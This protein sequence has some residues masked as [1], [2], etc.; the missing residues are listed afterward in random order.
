MAEAK[1]KKRKSKIRLK[2]SA[3]WTIASLFM[4]TAIIIALI[5]VQNGGVSAIAEY[6]VPSTIGEVLDGEN[7]TLKHGIVDGTSV[8]GVGTVEYAFPKDGDSQN[9]TD[10]TNGTTYTYTKIDMSTMDNK[11]VPVP[12]FSLAKNS[13]SATS[14]NCLSKYLGIAGSGSTPAGGTVNLG[15]DV[16]VGKDLPSA[17]TLEYDDKAT[18]TDQN[19]DGVVVTTYKETKHTTTMPNDS[20]ISYSY[21]DRVSKTKTYRWIVDDAELN[22][23]HLEFTESEWSTPEYFVK[24]NGSEDKNQRT[25]YYI[26]DGAFK[27]VGN[28]QTMTIPQNISKIGDSSFE[29]CS[30]LASV[31]IGI[32]CESI[33]DK[34]FAGCGNLNN[35]SFDTISNLKTIG[36]GAFA[37]IGA[38]SITLPSS[39]LSV[40]GSG[41]FFRCPNLS[42]F[43]MSNTN[44]TTGLK[45]GCYVFS[46]CPIS[47]ITLTNVTSIASHNSSGTLISNPATGSYSKD[48]AQCG[49]FTKQNDQSDTLRSVQFPAYSG[50]IPYGTF[51]GDNN[52]AYVRFFNDG[53]AYDWKDESEQQQ[54]ADE[55]YNEPDNFYIMGDTPTMSGPQAY[56]YAAANGITYGYM[57]GDV[58]TYELTKNGYKYTF[59]VLDDNNCV[60]T[61]IEPSEIVTPEDTMV[62][63]SK[64]AQ[65]NVKEIS[66]EAVKVS[67]IA[68]PSSLEIPDTIETIGDKAFTNM[69]NL[70]TVN[71]YDA[72]GSSSSP[73]ITLGNELFAGDK[74]LTNINIR[75]DAHDQQYVNDPN[76]VSVGTDAFKTQSDSLTIQ[77][78]MGEGYAPYDYA[79]NPNNLINGKSATAYIKYESGNP[80]NLSCQYDPMIENADGSKG[81]VSLL[82]YPTKETKISD[83]NKTI[84]DLIETPVDQRSIVDNQIIDSLKN[85]IV[86]TGITSIEKTKDDQGVNQYFQDLDTTTS[87]TLMDVSELP[88]NAFASTKHETGKTA[89]NDIIPSSLQSVAFADDI[90]DLGNTPFQ[91]SKNVTAVVFGGEGD[92]SSASEDDPYYWVENGIIYSYTGKDETGTNQIAI[93]ECL[94]SR[95]KE[96]TGT[97]A[98]VDDIRSDVSEIKDAAFK[99]CDTIKEVDLSPC[100]ELRE[101]PKDCFYDA[102]NLNEVRLPEDCDSIKESAFAVES[103]NNTAPENYIDVYVPDIEVYINA[104][105]F[106]NDKNATLHSYYDSAAEKF[107]KDHGNVDFKALT[108][109]VKATFL[110]YDAS[111]LSEETIDAG[112]QPDGPAT[113]PT[114]TGYNFIGWNP[115]ISKIYTDTVYV[116]QYELPS[117]SSSSSSS[118]SKTSSTTSGGSGSG[119]GGSGSA[120]TSSKSSSSS[121]SSKSTSSSS[122]TTSTTSAGAVIV[123]GAPAPYVATGSGAVANTNGNTTTGSTPV[124]GNNAQTGNTNVISTAPGISNN[125][126]MSAT[127][128]GSSDNYIIKITQTDEADAFAVQALS[129]AFGSLDNIR[130]MPFDISLYDSTGTTKI[131]PVPEGVTVSVTMPIPDD[132]TIYGGNNK[133]A[134][135]LNGAL[136]S[137]QPRFT[138]IDGI[139]CMNFT[140]SH[141]SPYVIYVDTANLQATGISDATPKTGDPIHPKWFLVIGFAAISIFLF[142]K[143]DRDAVSMKAA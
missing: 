50:T 99:N 51:A 131:T 137:I 49:I 63:P 132:L 25:I 83:D 98:T 74:K 52:L 141:L 7:S 35:L 48:K 73:A 128:N 37:G 104:N 72:D 32:N 6:A 121:S 133:V 105:A 43:D 130:Y 116:A 47:D 27:N 28:I 88:D 115:S 125:G 71:W 80:E 17:D 12:I 117:S 111:V 119:S 3:R 18:P 100:S 143:R 53:K 30:N 16:I 69:P 34:A 68:K 19:G 9:I 138:V 67:G 106:T 70:T 124:S 90:T 92:Q 86:P 29:G 127:V 109:R 26:A 75:D 89:L 13:N 84:K 38:Q 78:K 60:I 44:N 85:I 118:T 39:S 4:M 46:G 134:S 64:I 23:G 87:V 59:G 31:N 33:G 58:L 77:G 76:I 2:R 61:K 103:G 62:I 40:I 102:D 114:R 139:P 42:S 82:T 14:S 5:P 20:S 91:N 21:L 113:N 110:N 8:V 41:A 45:L 120:S 95:G 66:P 1:T 112:T 129:G 55:F 97:S 24:S 57:N 140:V 93:E 96:G 56:I 94:P 122:S 81:A 123:S 136:E 54:K 135:T 79:I 11:T 15:S 36:D 142:L 10:Y 101:I 22:T 126:K 107:A 108:D 65:Y